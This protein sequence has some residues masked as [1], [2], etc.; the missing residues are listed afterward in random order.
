LCL[1]LLVAVF[2][3]SIDL[4]RVASRRE[5]VFTTDLLLQ[6]ADLGREE[7]D[8][9]S[10]IGANHMVMTAPIVL[11]FES[12][13]P[14]MEGDF[15]GQPTFGQ[16]FQGSVDGGVPDAGVLFLHQ[17]VQFVGGEVVAGLQKCAQDGVALGGLLQAYPFEMSMKNFLRL[18]DHLAGK[19]GL[20]VD[21]LLKHGAVSQNTTGAS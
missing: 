16:E 19:R 3:D 14:V 7:F 11:M 10:A 9:T 5:V 2:T 18:A 20:I 17:A 13:N 21:A 15:A 6:L 8:G 4:K 12:G 1:I